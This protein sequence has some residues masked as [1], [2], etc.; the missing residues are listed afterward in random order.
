MPPR[1]APPPAVP[2]A[3][4]TCTTPPPRPPPAPHVAR[5]CAA[6]A[7]ALCLSGAVLGLWYAM[8]Y[9]RPPPPA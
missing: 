4:A 1:A 7:T 9:L 2:A 3:P 6:L 8:V 5:A